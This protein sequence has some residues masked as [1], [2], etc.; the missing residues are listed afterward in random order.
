MQTSGKYQKQHDFKSDS[1]SDF[2]NYHPIF[3]LPCLSKV[4]EQVFQCQLSNC[5]GKHYLLKSSQFGFHPQRSTELAY[6]LL[7]DDIRKNIENHLLLGVIYLDL[8][9][10]FD[11]V[12]RLY[13]LSKLSS[14]GIY[15]NEFTWFE[16]YTFNR[17]QHV[18]YDGNLSKAFLVFRDVLQGLI[19]GPT[20]FLLHLDDID[21]CLHHFSI[22]KYADTVIY[23]SGNDSESIQKKLNADI[24]E[25][26]RSFLNLK[27]GKSETMIF[28]TSICVKK[29]ATLNIQIKGTSINQTY[30]YLGTHLD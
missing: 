22:I 4:L 10:A 18:F 25:V 28:G 8:S 1:K 26:C 12:C 11:A 13:L 19:L 16:N 9:K 30:K 14:Y 29:A 20:L 3:V 15:G 24:L 6:N 23:V 2:N 7:V 17:K 5:F 21:S 27:K